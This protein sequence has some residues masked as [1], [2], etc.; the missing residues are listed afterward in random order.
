M[1]FQSPDIYRSSENNLKIRKPGSDAGPK[2]LG[3]VLAELVESWGI[4]T[5]ILEAQ[6]VTYWGEVA[7]ESLSRVSEPLAIRHGTL[8]VSIEGSVWKHQFSFMKREIL[9]RINRRVGEE[10]IKDIIIATNKREKK[11]YGRDSRTIDD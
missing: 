11:E 10:I 5:K 6:A 8:F 9:E 3:A 2:S 7:G 4:R 1:R